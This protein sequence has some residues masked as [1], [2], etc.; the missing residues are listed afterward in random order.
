MKLT[1]KI[2]F[3]KYSFAKNELDKNGYTSAKVEKY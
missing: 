2:D 3:G 1:Y